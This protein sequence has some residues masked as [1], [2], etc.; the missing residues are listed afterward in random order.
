MRRV[1]LGV[2]GTT[3]RWFSAGL[4][5]RNQG[6]IYGPVGLDVPFPFPRLRLTLC[7][8]LSFYL[9][10]PVIPVSS[11][12]PSS[13]RFEMVLATNIVNG[14]H[15]GHISSLF[16]PHLRCD[17][18]FV[19]SPE[20]LKSLLHPHPFINPLFFYPTKLV[21]SPSTSILPLPLLILFLP[22]DGI[23]LVYLRLIY[24]AVIHDRWSPLLP[25]LA[26][27]LISRNSGFTASFWRT[28]PLFR[29]FVSSPIPLSSLF[30]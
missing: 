3:R 4:V 17:S 1:V 29:R 18:V 21:F 24:P 8:P 5:G 15:T 14:S 6:L 13:H 30:P 26:A 25:P 9:P 23:F 10:V 7:S 19:A 12:P 22:R 11:P 20:D 27:V 2:L 16:V 28:T